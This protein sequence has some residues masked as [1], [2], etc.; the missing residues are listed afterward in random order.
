LEDREY[1]P[2]IK[3]YTVYSYPPKPY[4]TKL[5]RGALT[6]VKGMGSRELSY[7]EVV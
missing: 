7:N 1:K 5:S 3:P 4:F 6:I 2:V